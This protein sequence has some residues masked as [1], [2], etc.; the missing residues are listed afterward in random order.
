MANIM[1]EKD[2]VAKINDPEAKTMGLA[3]GPGNVLIRI[4]NEGVTH[5]AGLQPNE[6]IQMGVGLIQLAQQAAAMQQQIQ[7][8]QMASKLVNGNVKEEGK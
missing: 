5:I 6:A 2:V 1:T 3:V 4:R 8:Q 7:Q